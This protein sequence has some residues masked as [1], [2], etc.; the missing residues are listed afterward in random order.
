MLTA[1]ER[2][3]YQKQLRLPEWGEDQQAKLAH[4]H[5][6]VVGAGGLGTAAL[7]YLVA[8]GVGRI[9]ILDDDLVELSNLGR[10]VIYKTQEVGFSKVAM[11][12][13][14]LQALN[15]NVDIQVI[16]EK[17]HRANGAQFVK[18]ADLILDCTDNFE[19]RYLINDFC[20]QFEKPF[21]YAAVH[22]WEGLLSVCNALIKDSKG[23]R[24][25]TYRCLFPEMPSSTEIP[26]CDEVG[27]LGFIPGVLGL[28]QAKESL[29]YLAG[30]SSPAQG[31]L[32][33]WDAKD[34]SLQHFKIDRSPTADSEIF[35]ETSR[36]QPTEISA[37]RAMK[38]L[39][40]TDYYLLDVR[41][42]HEL[43]LAAI[44]GC[45]HIPMNEIQEKY[46]L[47]PREKT[48]IVMC[49]H[50]IRSAYVIDYLR[51]NHGFENLVNLEGG[52]DAW[53][54]LADPQIPRY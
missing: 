29:F 5:I 4:S 10:Q 45:L 50:G 9:T 47:L 14:Y 51:S 37:S 11:A 15:P 54:K 1:N 19:T 53:S 30:F 25:A 24:T 27:V 22:A 34:M 8:A 43:N 32:V 44:P 13:Q 16:Q 41:E 36:D 39:K 28:F 7:P 35:P 48:G 21:V 26:N 23:L 38:L 40:N 31:A 46:S 33:R 6:L 52:I 18:D 20:V 2:L 42:D 12:K 3:R 17:F 49:H